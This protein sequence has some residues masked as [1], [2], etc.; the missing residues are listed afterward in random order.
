MVGRRRGGEG[1]E[2]MVVE[3]E[4]G[5]EGERGV[6][7]EGGD[8]EEGDGAGGGG[9]VGVT[10]AELADMIEKVLAAPP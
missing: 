8:G 9:D 3:G 5:R 1:G 10:Y 4:G 7:E 6:G 2:S